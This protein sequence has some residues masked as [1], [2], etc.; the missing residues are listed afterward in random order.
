MSPLG[1][2]TKLEIYSLSSV[3]S[4]LIPSLTNLK[5]TRPRNLES[6]QE[7]LFELV[8]LHFTFKLYNWSNFRLLTVSN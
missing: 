3:T 7:G 2:F 5:T 8:T 6:D 4:R 1:H